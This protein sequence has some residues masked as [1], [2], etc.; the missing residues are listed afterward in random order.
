MDGFWSA[1]P[2]H[3]FLHTFVYE[4]EGVILDKYEIINARMIHGGSGNL[5]PEVGLEVF[6]TQWLGDD[7][8]VKFRAEGM[9]PDHSM[10]MTKAG[11]QPGDRLGTDLYPEI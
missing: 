9:D 11:L 2:Y 3:G 10:I 6:N 4:H 8:R 1:A 7:V 5:D